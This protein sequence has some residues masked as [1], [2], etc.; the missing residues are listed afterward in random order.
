MRGKFWGKEGAH[1]Q[2]PPFGWPKWENTTWAKS[3]LLF[4]A[5]ILAC[6]AA[7]SASGKVS[8]ATA[9]PKNGFLGM[10]GSLLRAPC[11]PVACA[12]A[13]AQGTSELRDLAS[14][15]ASIYQG[16]WQFGPVSTSVR[17]TY[18]STS[19]PQLPWRAAP[20]SHQKRCARVLRCVVE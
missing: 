14:P 13:R 20:S 1:V 2:N 17:P 4:N 3:D 5:V 12:L 16:Q 7:T 15:C 19:R 10:H 18:T 8:A 9:S 6:S 11:T